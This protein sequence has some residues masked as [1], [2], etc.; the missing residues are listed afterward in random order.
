M[1]KKNFRL[2]LA[3]RLKSDKLFSCIIFAYAFFCL[4]S[5]IYF[6]IEGQVRNTL[7]CLLF[8]LFVP[9]MLVLEKV[10]KV[11][12]VALFSAVVLFIAA[13]S[14]LG[15]C[16]D[17]Y[18]LVPW[19]DLLLHCLSGFIFARLG[20]ALLELFIGEPMGTKSFFACLL[21]GAAVSLAIATLWELFEYAGTALFGLD[22]QEDKIIGGF[23]SYLLSGTHSE[24]FD[25]DGIIKTVIYYGNGQTLVLDGYLDIGLIDTIG[26]MAI[27]TLGVAVYAVAFVIDWFKGKKRL[28][29]AF[30]PK[31]D[32]IAPELKHEEYA[33][34]QRAKWEASPQSTE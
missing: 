23:N 2:Y 9:L 29:N 13:G 6:A 33:A 11:R 4:S 8:V 32:R 27:C 7:M 12:F 15:G 34:A 21:F 5:F 3:H 17:H 10:L 14:I 22:M 24:T 25:V 28:Y 26:D 1:R 20:F 16:Y 18:T 19:F 31:L 30:I